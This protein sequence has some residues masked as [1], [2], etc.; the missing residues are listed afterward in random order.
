[1]GHPL[2]D[3]WIVGLICNFPQVSKARIYQMLDDLAERSRKAGY[4]LRAVQMHRYR[5]ERFWNN[6][7]K[8][9]EYFHKMQEQ[10]KD[11][12]SNCSVCELDDQVGFAIYR[13][14]DERALELAQPLL[15]G[16][17]GC[18]T[19]PHRTYANV[20]LP[21]VRLGRQSEAIDYHR[22]GYRLVAGNQSFLDKVADH[23]IFL[24]LTEN[25]KRALEIFEKHYPWMEKNRDAYY[26]FRFLRSAWL[27]FEILGEQ[28]DK[29]LTAPQ[30]NLPRNSPLYSSAGPYDAVK[31]A[32]YFKQ[33][34]E[35]MGR[36]FDKRNETDHFAQTLAATPS[37]KALSAPF[38]LGES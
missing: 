29:S 18:A 33:Q 5:T 21:L 27:L 24:T 35:E 38:P 25:F 36:R 4:G 30:L 6:R 26:H 14:N 2:E 28:S 11:D 22:K 13:G 16:E 9:I 10:P 3:K 23:L 8:A 1:V 34:A 20:L 37:L 12:L 7:E 17:E 31:L 19:V 32:V 15:H